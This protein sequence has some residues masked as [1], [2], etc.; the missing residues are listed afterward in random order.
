MDTLP[1]AGSDGLDGQRTGGDTIWASGYCIYE[2]QYFESLEWIA[3]DFDSTKP[4]IAPNFGIARSKTQWLRTSTEGDL[5]KWVS[6]IRH[7][8]LEIR[9]D[10]IDV[11]A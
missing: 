2:C 5:Y 1:R 11:A 4:E 6:S 8:C 3:S 7:L 10:A 9:V